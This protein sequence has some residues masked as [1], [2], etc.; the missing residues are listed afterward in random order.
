MAKEYEIVTIDELTRMDKLQGIE[1]YYKHIIL[2]TG[3]IK[4]TVD[5]SAEDFTPE[6]VAPL[7]LKAATNADTIL[8]G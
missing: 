2:T 8:K 1:T 3:G 6:K 5:I 7:L 4:L